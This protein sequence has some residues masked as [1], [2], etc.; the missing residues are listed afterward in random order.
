MPTQ[1]TFKFIIGRYNGTMGMA[2]FSNGREVLHQEYFD[3]NSFEFTTEFSWPGTVVIKLF[4]KQFKDTEI[5][6]QG[7]ILND[8]YIKLDSLMIDKIVVDDEILRDFVNLD[9]ENQSLKELYWGFNGSVTLTFEEE[10]FF[11]WF[12]NQ[13]S[14]K[15][16]IGAEPS[17]APGRLF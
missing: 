4:N 14:K 9:T 6:S 12:L 11:L 5:D 7:N 8:K 1:I 10:D 2:I 16:N 15:Y 13:K 3:D 17:S